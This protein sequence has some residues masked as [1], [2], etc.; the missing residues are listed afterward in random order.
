MESEIL[1]CREATRLVSQAMD[2]HLTV[3]KRL[4][5]RVHMFMCKFCSRFEKQLK[6]IRKSARREVQAGDVAAMTPA[7]KA[8]LEK[9]V[10][11]HHAA[12]P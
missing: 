12:E 7:L 2:N 3:Q 8:R 11:E 1:N 4:E 9:T 6:S 5:L 10:R